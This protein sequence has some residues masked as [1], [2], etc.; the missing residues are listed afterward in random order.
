MDAILIRMATKDDLPRLTEIYNYYVVSTPVTFDVE[1][2]TVERR[3]TWFQQFGPTGRYRLLVAEQSGGVVGYAGTTRFRPKAAYD[4]T[5]E[6]TIYCDLSAAG[7]GI[8][9]RLY[10]ALFETIAGEDIHRILAGYT[11]PNPASAA[12]HQRFG[13]KPAGTFSENGRKFG[14]YWDVM[15]TERPL[16]LSGNM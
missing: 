13:F 14:R 8:G 9:R 15:W 12:L 11:L 2:Y 3:A 4:T 7:K 10:T 1:P 16:R 6:T 5:V